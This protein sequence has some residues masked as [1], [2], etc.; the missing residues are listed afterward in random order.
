MMMSF[1]V[2]LQEGED[3]EILAHA[4]TMVP[5]ND[6]AGSVAAY[7]AGGLEV[8]WRPDS[9][10]TLVGDSDRAYVLVEDDS[11]ERALGPGPVLLVDDLS[12]IDLGDCNSW[13]ISPMDVPVGRYAAV[14]RGGTVLRYLDL[15]AI[16]K[17]IPS[18][19]FGDSRSERRVE[20]DSIVSP[21]ASGII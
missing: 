4:F 13:A 6:L 5:A 21:G 11:T 18:I 9:Q 1:L 10:T 3:L 16:D 17:R 7:L 15:S 19:W 12:T 14:D 2:R 8:L 20:A